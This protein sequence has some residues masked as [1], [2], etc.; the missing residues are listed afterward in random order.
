MINKQKRMLDSDKWQ[1][2]K[3]AQRG[4]GE[5]VWGRISFLDRLTPEGHKGKCHA[6]TRSREN[7][8]PANAQVLM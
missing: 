7:S 4:Q 2:E 1:G 3:K 6:D 5:S 8:T